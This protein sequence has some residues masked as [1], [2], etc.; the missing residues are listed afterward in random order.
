MRP[1][2]FSFVCLALNL[3]ALTLLGYCW[4][5]LSIDR[6]FSMGTGIYGLIAIGLLLSSS[7]IFYLTTQEFLFK[8][9]WWVTAL[10]ILVLIVKL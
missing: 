3:L 8:C 5:L 9:I 7:I 6:G 2:I 10:C 1:Y 4:H